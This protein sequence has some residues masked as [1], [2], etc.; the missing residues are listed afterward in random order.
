MAEKWVE[1]FS[2]DDYDQ[3]YDTAVIR[4][5]PP[6]SN[7]DCILA[8]VVHSFNFKP[9]P[10]AVVI[11]LV[12]DNGQNLILKLNPLL[13]NMMVTNLTMCGQAARWMDSAGAIVI[14]YVL[15]SR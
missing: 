5:P 6:P 1:A 14:P 8:P 10:N 11:S 13:A 7:F 3:W 2:L 4:T 12:L 9:F 15:E